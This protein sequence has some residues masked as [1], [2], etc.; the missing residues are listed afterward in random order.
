M[1]K[2]K[3]VFQLTWAFEN[4][5]EHESFYTKRMF[6]GLAAHCHGKMVMVLVENPGEKEY[7]DKTFEFDVWNGILFPTEYEHQ[8]KL[9]KKIKNLIQHPV[10]KK[11]L[12]LPLESSS[13]EDDVEE[14][15]QMIRRNND[16][17]GI[18]P[19]MD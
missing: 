1:A 9:Q 17:L 10:L 5:E 8:D 12:Y 6:G 14:L 3:K 13:F 18:Y 2:K 7:R 15:S 19:K 16:L 4:F 11:W